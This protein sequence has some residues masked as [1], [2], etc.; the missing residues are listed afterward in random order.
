MEQKYNGFKEYEKELIEG[1]E[2]NLS[3]I[4]ENINSTKKT[5]DLLGN[6]LELYVPKALDSLGKLIVSHPPIKFK[7]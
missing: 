6:I 4:N 7:K 1:S 3:T 2:E 5:F